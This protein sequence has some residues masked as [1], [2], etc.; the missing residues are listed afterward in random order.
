MSSSQYR[1][2]VVD[3][4][5]AVRRLAVRAFSDAGFECN[6]VVDGTQAGALLDL[7]HYDLLLTDLRMAGGNGHVLALKALAKPRR[8][9]VAVLTGVMEPRLAAD[10]I[11]RGVDD[12]I[13]KPVDFP[14]LATKL[15]GLLDRRPR[16][17]APRLEAAGALERDDSG[18]DGISEIPSNALDLE[19]TVT[20]LSHMLPISQA[21][22]DVVQLTAGDD[23]SAQRIATAVAQD[24]S[25]AVEILRVANSNFY[26]SSGKKVT[27]V[28][29]AVVRIGTKRVGEVALGTSALSALTQRALPWLDTKLIWRQSIAAG[30]ALHSLVRNGKFNDDTGLLLSVLTQDLGRIVLGML[31]PKTYVQM[32]LACE[33]SD[34]SLLEQEDHVF[35]S[36]HPEVMAWLLA[37]WGLPATVY[38]P[39]RYAVS[40]Y[41]EIEALDE[42]LRSKVELTKLAGL[43]GRLAVSRWEPWELVD[44]MPGPVYVRLNLMPIDELVAE[45]RAEFQAIL[46]LKT[47][48]AGGSSPTNATR[49]GGDSRRVGYA[50]LSSQKGDVLPELMQS[51]G[52][53][54]NILEPEAIPVET[55]LVINCHG[56]PARRLAPYLDQ[57][58]SNERRLIVTDSRHSAEYVAFGRVV[59]LPCSH[60]HFS[61]A[62]AAVAA[63][64]LDDCRCSGLGNP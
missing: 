41:D 36:R 21:A 38:R 46:E 50:T 33:A 39:L 60:S 56:V 32:R 58:A 5:D 43:I 24:A 16:Q 52:L 25:L 7:V 34:S 22:L 20:S 37:K 9:L 59:S 61:R 45:S 62:C 4:D 1:A 64:T 44:P 53:A 15:K 12:I 13:F 55:N 63:E 10:L 47:E 23:V 28:Y 18:A 49:Q 42:P 48:S 27:D 30:I 29:E 54:V 51:M 6:D 14:L 11:A 26:D 19:R 3:D 35:P 17:E 57:N 2:L 31:Y 8:P 40:A